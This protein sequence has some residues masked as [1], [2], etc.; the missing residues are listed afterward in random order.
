MS[1]TLEAAREALADAYL[2]TGDY[3]PA[4][5]LADRALR[6][7][8]TLG[9][10]RGEAAA[11]AQ[12]GMV[13]HFRAVELPREERAS[14]D[15]GPE[16]ALFE[17]ALAMRHEIGDEHGVAE[18]S[19]QVGLVHQVLRGDSEAAA[20]YFRDALE[21]VER[22]PD[23]DPWLR[24]EVYRHVGF[25]RLLDEDYDPALTYLRRSQ[26][27]RDELADTRWRAGGL[28]ALAMASRLAGKPGEAAAY[29]RRAI[30]TARADGLAERHV[31]A[32]EAELR[33]A[34]ERL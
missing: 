15:H 25:D 4:T 3:E 24:S 14:L 31:A 30:E 32:A 18:S 19:W 21:L 5:R 33:A 22:L 26:D 16:L 2:H 27:V 9:E 17:Q 13:L 23:V 11:L 10:R 34:A 7:A 8:R 28:T 12:K 1:S 29:A 6:G 20:P